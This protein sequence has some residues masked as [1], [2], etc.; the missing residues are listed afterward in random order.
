MN[1]V[2][3]DQFVDFECQKVKLVRTKEFPAIIDLF[4][5]SV[6]FIQLRGMLV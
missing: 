3:L 2:L 4:F 6:G 5:N 1:T